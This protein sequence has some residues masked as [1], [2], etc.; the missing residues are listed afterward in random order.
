MSSCIYCPTG[1][2][3][4]ANSK[5]HWVP[6]WLGT[7]LRA[8]TLLDRLCAGCNER[9][10]RELDTP[11]SRTGPEALERYRRGIRGRRGTVANPFRYRGQSANPPTIFTANLPGFEA[12]LLME[13]ASGGGGAPKARPLPQIIIRDTSGVQ[14]AVPLPTGIEDERAGPWL[15]KALDER[16]LAGATLEALLCDKAE[17][18]VGEINQGGE[19]PIWLRKALLHVFGKPD[20]F[21]HYLLD[22]GSETSSRVEIKLEINIAYARAIAKFA[23][24]YALKQLEWLDGHDPTFV[25]IKRFILE[26]AGHP[27]DFLDLDAPPFLLGV[28]GE[29]PA[30]GHFMLLNVGRESVTVLLKTFVHSPYSRD[31]VRVR[32]GPTPPSALRFPVLGHQLR[33]YEGGPKQ[34]HDGEILPLKTMYF[35]GRWGVIVAPG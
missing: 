33:I 13:D 1:A 15:Q 17:T 8:D 9:L 14:Q 10:G 23:F 3:K 31:A 4:P 2:P 22:G 19:L 12:P 34:G 35:G 16:G 6:R 21:T 28:V 18:L 26:G 30:D 7:F 32:L 24:H 25:P 5:E 11:M 27:N 29:R 20:G